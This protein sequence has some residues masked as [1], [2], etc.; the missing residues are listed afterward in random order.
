M[1]G[2]NGLLWLVQGNETV[3]HR[4]ECSLAGLVQAHFASIRDGDAAQD[5]THERED[6]A[7]VQLSG[8]ALGH[9]DGGHS[10]GH[11]QITYISQ[12]RVLGVLVAWA[13]YSSINE[14]Q[15]EGLTVQTLL[16][17]IE[18]SAAVHLQGF[19]PNLSQCCQVAGFGGVANGGDHVPAV[20]EQA[21]YQAKAQ[22]AGGADD[23]G[24]FLRRHEELL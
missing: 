23:Q 22:A 3:D 4:V 15:I 6:A 7:V 21:F 16:K 13:H 19:Y 14:Q 18:L 24:G 12:L 9:A 1:H 5:R 2:Q 17:C 8:E 11:E 20:F 10:V